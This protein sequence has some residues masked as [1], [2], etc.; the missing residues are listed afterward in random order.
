MIVGGLDFG[1]SVV[2]ER[3]RMNVGVD[4]TLVL[5]FGGEILNSFGSIYKI[6]N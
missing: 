5:W 2:R 4:V 1:F 6:Y 3:K